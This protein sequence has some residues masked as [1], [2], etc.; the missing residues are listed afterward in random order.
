MDVK[1]IDP[2]KEDESSGSESLKRGFLERLL[3]LLLGTND[4]EKEKKRL[5]KNIAKELK[6]NKYKFY[7]PKGRLALPAMAKFFHEIFKVVGPAQVL[8]QNA[9]S[10]GALR[11]LLIES[12]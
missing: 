6:R 5:L 7:N 4:P 12:S 2:L 11:T 10:S 8:L 3:S 1:G 9:A